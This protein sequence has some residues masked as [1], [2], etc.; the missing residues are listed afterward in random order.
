[1]IIHLQSK[2]QKV[3]A[4]STALSG[5]QCHIILAKACSV[6]SHQPR[7]ARCTMLRIS[8][9][10]RHTHQPWCTLYY[11]SQGVQRHKNSI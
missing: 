2:K 10:P 11:I 8:H 7:H 5:V 9:Q 3:E 6:R 1:M 4:A